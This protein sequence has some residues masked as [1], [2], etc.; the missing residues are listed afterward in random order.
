MKLTNTV[1]R[2][3]IMCHVPSRTMRAAMAAGYPTVLA[4]AEKPLGSP[5]TTRLMCL[6][7]SSPVGWRSPTSFLRMIMSRSPFSDGRDVISTLRASFTCSQSNRL[8][9]HRKRVWLPGVLS[10]QPE[11]C[12]RAAPARRSAFQT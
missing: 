3:I 12:R 9:S 1:V 11:R 6:V 7:S 10:A 5:Y 8:V 2:R 4:M